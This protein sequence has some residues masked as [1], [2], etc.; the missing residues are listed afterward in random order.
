MDI[1]MTLLM[2][3]THCTKEFQTNGL[4]AFAM[5]S[6]CTGCVPNI[7]SRK[8]NKILGCK[9]RKTSSTKWLHSTCI[10]ANIYSKFLN[11]IE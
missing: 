1:I 10:Y 2:K 6:F 3:T 11:T 5:R 8:I 4:Y 9:I 7:V